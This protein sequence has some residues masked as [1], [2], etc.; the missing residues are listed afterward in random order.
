MTHWPV[1]MCDVTDFKVRAMTHWYVR[2][3]WFQGACRDLLILECYSF[4]HWHVWHRK[5]S[6][7]RHACQVIHLCDMTHSSVWHDSF[8]CVPWL[9]HMCAMTWLDTHASWMRHEACVTWLRIKCVWHDSLACVQVWHDSFGMHTCQWVMPHRIH[10]VTLWVMPRVT[11]LRWDMT[12]LSHVARDMTQ[13]VTLR[14]CVTCLI[15]TCAFWMSHDSPESCRTRYDSES[16][17]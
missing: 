5:D 3:D 12:H 17:T 16:A 9:I 14:M 2:R 7:M 8:I 15:D 6:F 10:N 1:R 4:T 11:W 13:R